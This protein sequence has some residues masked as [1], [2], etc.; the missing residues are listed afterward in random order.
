MFLGVIVLEQGS[1]QRF[2]LVIEQSL[3]SLLL[4][5]QIK[6]LLQIAHKRRCHNPLLQHTI[7]L[8]LF[9]WFFNSFQLLLLI[10]SEQHRTGLDIFFWELGPHVF[11]PAF[12]RE[13]WCI[14][15]LE[16]LFLGDLFSHIRLH[17]DDTAAE[18]A[19][20]Y[21]DYFVGEVSG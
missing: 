20:D 13:E 6:I 5:Q 2:L 3:H 18:N 14:F 8:H 19:V 9:L 12:E 7:L 21:R 16:Q 15:K 17:R 4:L 11:R 10:F 1:D